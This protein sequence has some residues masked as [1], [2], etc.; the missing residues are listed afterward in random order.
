MIWIIGGTSDAASIAEKIH[1]EGFEAIVT[2]TT[3]YGKILLTGRL[4][5]KIESG[6]LD[7]DDMQVFIDKHMINLILDASHPYATEVSKN[8]IKAAESKGINYLRYERKSFEIQS[9]DNIRT[10]SN[11]DSVITYL[12]NSS[13]NI[14]L[15]IGS[16]NARLFKDIEKKRIYV[17]VLPLSESVKVCEEAGFLTDNII[18]VKGNFSKEFNMVL[19]REFDI[20]FLVTKDSGIEGGVPEKI[21]A[22]SHNGIE[23]L[24]LERPAI[25]YPE[26]YSD[27]DAL[28]QRINEL[29]EETV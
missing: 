25:N 29:S 5:T 21:E 17:R 18:A 16:K 8:A 6:K 22:A 20:K 26:I 1:R 10:F 3:E 2:T 13:G 12:K 19:M 15:T 4:N 24:M 9:Y 23:V 28:L 14:L 11:Y 27:I 7:V